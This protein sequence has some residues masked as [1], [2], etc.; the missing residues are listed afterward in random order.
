[1]VPQ[2]FG[3][4]P[5]GERIK[6]IE[7][8]QKRQVMPEMKRNYHM[9][10]IMLFAAIA[11]LNPGQGLANCDHCKKGVNDKIIQ[12]IDSYVQKVKEEW[13]LTGVAASFA[14][15]GEVF[16]SKA[17]G[18]KEIG[19][20][21]AIDV[22]TVFQI[23]SVSKSF[24]AA[25][26][27]SL[28][29]EGKVSW[30]DTVVNILPDFKMYDPWVTANMQ[31]KDVM[32]HKSGLGGQVGTYLPNLGY[33]RDDIYKM[34][35]LIKPSYS[36]R[37]DYQYNNIT[38]IIAAKIIEKVTGK[39]WEENVQERI[40][41]PLGMTSSSMNGEGFLATE[42]KAV[43]HEYIYKDGIV[44]RALHGDDQAL[45]WL[46]VIGP[47]GSINSNVGDMIKY[48]DFHKNNGVNAE[49]KQI[50]SE[51]QMKYL[52]K[53]LTITSQDTNRTTLY[54]HC[55][56]IEQNNRYR[57][58]FHTGTTWGF[59][60]LCFFVPQLDLS[61]IMFMNCEVDSDPRYAIM[62]RLIDLMMGAPVEGF[63]P[64]F[65]DYSK[66]SLDKYIASEIKSAE[67]AAAK[68]AEDRAA[69][70]LKELPAP[71]AS[72]I[73]GKYVKDE[74]WG[75]AFITSEKDGLYIAV[76]KKGFKNKLEHKNG[77]SYTFWSDGHKFTI[78]FSLDEKGKK[79]TGFIIDLQKGEEKSVG[80]WV[81]E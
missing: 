10:A 52:H 17:Y 60:T 55:W 75:D 4:K 26:M 2:A 59:A 62:R 79:S 24:T 19:Q 56:F 45:W 36:F 7:E 21:D 74:L 33:D 42:N 16:Y 28:V 65:K 27:A 1:M 38:F 41:N 76:G 5:K 31:V 30:E 34:M 43:P 70:K 57:L 50:I 9:M 29:D 6:R 44:T 18:L 13:H 53:G 69:G 63:T 14:K 64:E 72:A 49:G 35:A 15:G 81:R 73:T 67:E 37:N 77:N 8:I 68:E 20:P 47:A 40:F 58:Y 12:S 39:S 51:K 11:V 78:H 71:K 22:N 25:V 32:T 66:E 46:T 61:G 54:G 48:A 23:G 80:G 3:N